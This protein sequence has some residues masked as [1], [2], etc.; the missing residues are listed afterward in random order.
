VPHREEP[1]NALCGVVNREVRFS[2]LNRPR[3][4]VSGWQAKV[5]QD[6]QS[7]G[8]SPASAI[9]PGLV[10]VRGRRRLFNKRSHALPHLAR[11]VE[12]RHSATLDEHLA[13]LVQ[14][15]ARFSFR[16]GRISRSSLSQLTERPVPTGRRAHPEG[17]A[18]TSGVGQRAAAPTDSNSEIILAHCGPS[19]V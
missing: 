17:R 19:V 7:K 2:S 16:W 9:S 15:A 12:S 6:L 13:W 4:D 8:N 3:P 10:R 14:A 1:N 11:H 5:F 18:Q